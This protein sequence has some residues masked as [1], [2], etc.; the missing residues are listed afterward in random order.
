ML[1]QLVLVLGPEF[2]LSHKQAVVEQWRWNISQNPSEV[3]GG[4]C[5]H[6]AASTYYLAPPTTSDSV[7]AERIIFENQI[8][9]WHDGMKVVVIP[10]F[11]KQ[12]PRITETRENCTCISLPMHVPFPWHTMTTPPSPPYLCLDHRAIVVTVEKLLSHLTDLRSS[13]TP[14]RCFQAAQTERQLLLL[15]Q[16]SDLQL[17]Y[18]DCSRMESESSPCPE[19]CLSPPPLEPVDHPEPAPQ[20]DQAFPKTRHQ[21]VVITED[22]GSVPV[23]TE[24]HNLPQPM[25]KPLLRIRKDVAMDTKPR[26]PS[27]FHG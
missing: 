26:K 3:G 6:D 11:W 1:W 13:P 20:K 21:S 14:G 23:G 16:I 7:P 15:G 17:Q 12:F 22:G 2:S 8:G 27:T 19:V 9:V 25:A 5:R 10:G 18:C 24:L 4:C